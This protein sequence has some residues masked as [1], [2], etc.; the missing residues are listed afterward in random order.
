MRHCGILKDQGSPVTGHQWSFD[1]FRGSEVAPGRSLDL[2]FQPA[3]TTHPRLITS[4][5]VRAQLLDLG[6]IALIHRIAINKVAF[7]GGTRRQT[8]ALV[9]AP[10]DTQV[11]RTVG[12]TQ[13]DLSW[14]RSRREHYTDQAGDEP[15]HSCLRKLLAGTGRYRR[16]CSQCFWRNAAKPVRRAIGKHAFREL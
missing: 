3:G 2:S 4:S 5:D 16:C 9:R 1:W 13:I 14:R 7:V 11:D 10:I 8:L 12:L 15:I 6:A